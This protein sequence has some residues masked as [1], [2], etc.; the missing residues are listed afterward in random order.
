MAYEGYLELGGTEIINAART[1]AYVGSL[2]PTFGLKGC[3]DC[4]GLVEALG[5][6][7]VLG[8]EQ[9]QGLLGVVNHN[10]ANEARPRVANAAFSDWS[11]TTAA[12]AT[13]TG[14]IADTA[15]SVQG[16]LGVFRV[17]GT[18]STSGQWGTVEYDENSLKFWTLDVGTNGS[19]TRMWMSV[20]V[21]SA[22]ATGVRLVARFYDE[23]S[24]LLYTSETVTYSGS[25]LDWRRLGVEVTDNVLR[26]A[27]QVILSITPT[28]GPSAAGTIQF[29]NILIQANTAPGGTEMWK[30][31][32]DWEMADTL[33]YDYVGAGL[34]VYSQRTIL[35][36]YDTDRQVLEQ[37]E[38]QT[39]LQDGAPWV[40][41][42][43]P[44][45]VNFWGFYPL[46]WSGVDDGTREVPVTELIGDGA[47]AGRSRAASRDMRFEGMLL[48]KDERA[49]A[50]GLA[51]LNRALDATRCD[52]PG[53]PCKGES[54]KFFSSCPPACGYD[55]CMDNPISFDFADGSDVEAWQAWVP[56]PTGN[57]Y[58][59]SFGGNCDMPGLRM[60]GLR[61]GR[62]YTFSRK[63]GGFVPG[64]WYT[65]RF[66]LTDGGDLTTAAIAE[67]PSVTVPSGAF[68]GI[69]DTRSIFTMSW[70]ATSDVQTMQV[71]IRVTDNDPQWSDPN[72]TASVLL[73]SLE[74]V[75]VV[76]P[77]V[78]YSTTFPDN[79]SLLN[80]WEV[81]P[82]TTN[83]SS[84]VQRLWTGAGAAVRFTAQAAG[85]TVPAGDLVYR[86]FRNLVP[87]QTYRVTLSTTLGSLN[88]A[89]PSLSWGLSGD[90]EPVVWDNSSSVPTATTV[91]E[92][93]ATQ[94]SHLIT[95]YLDSPITLAAQWDSL[96]IELLF[97]S[98]ERVPDDDERLPHPNPGRRYERNLHRV[99]AIQ[100]PRV[101]EHYSKECGAMMRVSFGLNAG[102]PFLYGATQE[103][104]SAFGG[105]SS[106][107]PDI[108]C[109]NGGQVRTNLVPNPSVETNSTGWSSSGVGTFTRVTGGAC[110]SWQMRRSV[111]PNNKDTEVVI[112]VA[113]AIPI[114]GG[115]PYTFSISLLRAMTLNPN[116]EFPGSLEIVWNT[117]EVSSAPFYR[118]PV[119]I[120]T[121]EPGAAVRSVTGFAPDGATSATLRV[122][123]KPEVTVA[124]GLNLDCAL[125]ELGTTSLVYFDGSSI[126][127]SWNG[128]PNASS[129]TLVPSQYD[130]LMDPDC[131]PMPE[132]PQPPQI[133]EDCWEA[134]GSWQRYAIQVPKI[135]VPVNSSALPIVHLSAGDVA[136]RQLRMRWYPD[137]DILGA[138]GLEECAYEAEITVSY[139]PAFTDMVIDSITHEATATQ[140]DYGERSA[141]HLLYGPNNG[142]VQW[143]ELRCGI[144]YVFTLDVSTDDDVGELDVFLDL[145][146]RV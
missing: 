66:N 142:P 44:D 45:S 139:M 131:P 43:D 94:T 15:S 11:W 95:L 127:A 99:V 60:S 113:S 129:S 115:Y 77:T 7:N 39:P 41:P 18:A 53:V 130:F 69:C 133:P 9:R 72:G 49:L 35:R 58:Y 108:T 111:P 59:D 123:Y 2:M 38:Y 56:S 114:T 82:N 20:A 132:P 57:V 103:V 143:P 55:P 86:W 36:H 116:K 61:D 83:I 50:S 128:T 21:Q 6:V 125:F 52:G 64:E 48:G 144:P 10:L 71:K 121:N 124:W 14:A 122:R 40:D 54:M 22:V 110:G 106:L 25:M 141:N 34:D 109:V 75:R 119:A 28:S 12:G 85:A 117:G 90:T 134:I 100:G 30:E 31:Y 73:N 8:D 62:E 146:V 92:F 32:A 4:A 1:E 140:T 84:S 105:S 70:R 63:V 16:L 107:V 5:A 102:V 27:N 89:V 47:V 118:P 138:G 19:A 87:G 101:E 17:T 112:T 135:M 29:S 13:A 26:D 33:A 67:G 126:D 76:A 91:M 93:V 88:Q 23:D 97:A 81:R 98:L 24:N 96:Y 104:G 51:W 79:G 80:G 137:P 37:R 78:I 68:W 42:T 120:T 136:S 74:V 65:A 145:G 3:Q 46:E